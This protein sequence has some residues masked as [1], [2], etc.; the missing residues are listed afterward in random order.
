MC[1]QKIKCIRQDSCFL[2]ETVAGSEKRYGFWVK[3]RL[4]TV[5]A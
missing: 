3:S 2:L 4:V 5:N 1:E